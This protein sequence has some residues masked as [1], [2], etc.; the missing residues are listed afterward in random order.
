MAQWRLTALPRY[1]HQEDVERLIATCDRAS[2][3]GL[4]DRAI[5]LLLSR[6]ALRASDVGQLQLSGVDWKGGTIIVS[7]KARRETRMPLPQEVGDAIL[8]YLE[9]ARPTAKSGALFLCNTPPFHPFRPG[10]M[11]GIT[12]RAVRRAGIKAPSHGTHMLRHSAAT[13]MLRRGASLEQVRSVLRHRS[14]E[15]TLVYAKV[16]LNALK[17]IAQPWPTVPPC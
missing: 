2:T 10:S 11:Y 1:I 9:R 5:L 16:D 12:Q 6:L 15:T 17:E 13:E 8:E 7:G 14:P 3:L 4:R